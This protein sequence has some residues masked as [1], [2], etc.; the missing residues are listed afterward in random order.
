MTD[1][2]TLQ[3]RVQSLEVAAAT[4]NLSALAGAGVAADSATSGLTATMTKFL[5]PVAVVAAGLAAL[6]K[7]IAV[8]REFDVLNAQLITATG[9][10]ED[11]AKAFEAIQ[12][13]AQSTPYDLAQATDAFNKLV[14]LGLTPSEAALT[15]YGNTASAM[16]KDL[17]QLVEAVADAA[18]GEFE[19]LK[20]FGIKSKNLGDEIA[21]TF[22]GVTTT[23]GNNAAE[24][25]G[26]LQDLGNN[27]FAG[28]MA[29]R[30]ETLDGAIS[31]LG[32]E[33]DKLFLNISSKGVGSAVEDT[34]RLAISG[35]EVLN[36]FLSSGELEGY[37][38]AF[39]M[40]FSGF[41]DS[42]AE[43]MEIT[44]TYVSGL[45]N[46]FLGT[47]GGGG[48]AFATTETIDFIIDAFKNM[49]E[50]I[51]AVIQLLAVEI[52]SLVDYGQLYGEAFGD[53]LG[54][55]LAKTVEKG[56]AYGKALGQG[57]NPFSDDSFD[58]EARLRE[59]DDLASEM[60]NDALARA[61]EQAKITREARRD[62]ILGIVE[63]RDV[64][65]ASF[66]T[67]ITAVQKLRDEYDKANAARDANTSDRLAAFKITPDQEEDGGDTALTKVQL[68]Q[69]KALENL[70][71]S[72]RTEE[73]VIQESY[74]KR[75]AIVLQ[76]TEE[77]SIQQEEL[78]RRLEAEFATQALGDLNVTDTHEEE[79]NAL[80]SYYESRR[81]LILSNTLLTE[82]AR[83]ALEMEL[84]KQRDERLQELESE[85]LSTTLTNNANLFGE[86]ADL[87]KEFGGEQS[88]A[89]KA[90][91]AVS[92]AFAL[93]DAVVKIQQGIAAAS[94]LPFPTNLPA[95]ASTVAAT[96]G[97]VSTISGSNFSGAYDNGGTIPQGKVGLVGEFGPEIVEGP[98]NVRS[99][100]ET[101]EMF[102]GGGDK[103]QAS[104]VPAPQVNLKNINVLDPTVVGDYLN[105]DD[106]EQLIMNVVQRNQR[107]MGF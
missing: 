71:L 77:G 79:L 61:D 20:E 16:G 51:H 57:L 7:T 89:Y 23:V 65:I 38:D 68:A 48:L 34:V 83:T 41:G 46:E 58:L 97:V 101:A 32:D 62:S 21:F 45:W 8:T 19:R 69:Q 81:E 13:F 17:I 80:N 73:E 44:T 55:Q 70:R 103:E 90:M 102:N 29:Q 11:A 56:K 12:D 50:N 6:T 72:L 60:S 2:A 39:V 64:A 93:A 88:D 87:T 84:T 5:G 43:T 33:W 92:K 4:A 107:A 91:F 35:L 31:N 9:S 28:A 98:A 94:A 3:I 78:K 76:N 59:L 54:T 53:V 63:E 82:E 49:P 105:T 104:P 40:K 95:I 74:S 47:S 42:I 14:N 66:S 99:R 30:V 106:G 10:S 27:E 1:L 22:R 18:T 85:R 67:Q 36:D 96:A 37:I 75:L 52:A 100:R 26:F 25:E 86:L 24:I 15:S